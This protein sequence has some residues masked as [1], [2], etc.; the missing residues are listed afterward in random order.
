MVMVKSIFEWLGFLQILATIFV[1]ECDS[2]DRMDYTRWIISMMYFLS[3]NKLMFFCDEVTAQRLRKFGG[4]KNSSLLDS[5][6]LNFL[7][8]VSKPPGLLLEILHLS[9]RNGGRVK[10]ITSRHQ[11]GE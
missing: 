4:F 1:V 2:D 11:C 5:Q 9:E 7:Q 10:E 6:V 3:T 8:F